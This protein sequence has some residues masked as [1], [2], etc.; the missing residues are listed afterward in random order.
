MASSADIDGIAKSGQG[1]Y[2]LRHK[3]VEG[4]VGKGSATT[5]I[6]KQRSSTAFVL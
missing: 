3:S 4:R 6:L 1:L 5:I 2:K